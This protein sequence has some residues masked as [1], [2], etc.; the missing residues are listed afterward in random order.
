MSLLKAMRVR[1][2]VSLT[3]IWACSLYSPVMAQSRPAGIDAAELDR[4]AT[5]LMEQSDLTGLAVALVEDGDISFVKGYGERLRGSGQPITPDTVFRWASVSKSVS[6]AAL[7]GLME[8]GQVD[9]DVPIEDL[10]PSLRLPPTDNKHR[11]IDLLAHRIGIARNAFDGWIESGS[12]AKPL[13]GDL[14]ELDYK[15]PPRTCHTYQN[16]AYDAAAEIIEEATEL[17]YKSVI[18]QELFDPI[19]MNT[20]SLTR[21]GLINSRNWARPHG[22]Y[23]QP[24]R[25]VQRTYYRLPAAAGVNSSVTDLA[26]W[27]VALMPQGAG[28]DET[29]FIPEERLQAMQTPIVPTLNEQRFMNRRF[30]AL[31]NSH[32]GLGLRIYNYDG[33][34]VVGHRG[35]VDGYRALILFAPDRRAGIAMMWNSPHSQPIGLQL[36][37]MDQL[38]GLPKRDWLRLNE[39]AIR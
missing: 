38:F 9:P 7:L 36:E 2:S 1:L 10:A 31:R 15:C 18:Q 14:V 11:V 13:R 30:G 23:G 22:R 4:R 17:P 21:E 24:I 5:T 19:G 39:S 16:V 29:G 6:A 12:A 33:Y 3:L 20:A 34:K 8:T 35:G 37:F 25:R 28:T 26:R 27:M 32:Y